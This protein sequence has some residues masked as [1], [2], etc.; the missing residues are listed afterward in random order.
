LR[1][2]AGDVVNIP[3]GVL[4]DFGA[5]ADEDVWVVDLTSP[6]FDPEKMNFDPAREDEISAAFEKAA[7]A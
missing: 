3:V 1:L 5:A 4:H 6:P 7:R 2:E